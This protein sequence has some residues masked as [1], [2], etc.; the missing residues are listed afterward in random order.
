VVA[1]CGQWHDSQL[2]IGTTEM[3]VFW[4]LLRQLWQT[5]QLMWSVRNG[6]AWKGRCRHYTCCYQLPMG[7][8]DL[9]GCNSPPPPM[10][11]PNEV[12][13][14]LCMQPVC[15]GLI[16]QSNDTISL[17]RPHDTSTHDLLV[18]AMKSCKPFH[19]YLVL[20]S[21]FSQTNLEARAFLAVRTMR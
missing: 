19:Q 6:S 18:S 10:S 5:S 15:A 11:V 3:A 7:L 12:F 4:K 2:R 21:C 8:S 1:H 13:L 20:L 17:P 16:V 14:C 9:S